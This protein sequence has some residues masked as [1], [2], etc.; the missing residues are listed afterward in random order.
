MSGNKN[1]EAIWDL[2]NRTLPERNQERLDV[3]KIALC[4][5]YRG[6]EKPKAGTIW[7]LNC[8]SCFQWISDNP[9]HWTDTKRI[10]NT[11]GHDKFKH[12]KNVGL[13][14]VC[15]KCG[16]GQLLDDDDGRATEEREL[17]DR[18]AVA[19]GR[20][21]EQIPAFRM[22]SFSQWSKEEIAI[23]I[24]D[25]LQPSKEAEKIRSETLRLHKE[26][27]AFWSIIN[28]QE[29][30]SRIIKDLK[31]ESIALRSASKI[32]FSV[33]GSHDVY[34]EKIEDNSYAYELEYMDGVAWTPLLIL[35]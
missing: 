34:I 20:P 15:K 1:S 3:E 16:A 25:K 4:K 18:I 11:C 22:S 17:S 27:P 23:T 14:L 35:V 7:R 31:C 19:I 12:D 26:F 8:G 10:C 29:A 6:L 30:I 33:D 28:R 2:L 24:V 13:F 32:L 5:K 21:T 9:L